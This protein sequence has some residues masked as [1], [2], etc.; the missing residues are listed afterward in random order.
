MND[1]ILNSYLSTCQMRLA[2]VERII[3]REITKEH[4]DRQWHLLDF[5]YRERAV[6]SFAISLLT[7]VRSEYLM[8]HPIGREQ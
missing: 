1:K 3:D 4:K 2:C 7:Q 5:L 8:Q 6:Y